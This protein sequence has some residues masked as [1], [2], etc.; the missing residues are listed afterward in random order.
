[1]DQIDRRPSEQHEIR[2]PRSDA[3]NGCLPS[4][5]DS[6]EAA[7]KLMLATLRFGLSIE[8]VAAAVQMSKGHFQRLFKRATGTTPHNWR[9]GQKVRVSQTDLLTGDFGLTEIAHRYGFADHA[10]YTR[11]FKQVVGTSPRAWREH[12]A[13]YDAAGSSTLTDG[14]E[15]G[16]SEASG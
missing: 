9:L 3:V 6:I 14:F 16:R 11:V 8:A 15:A 5:Q 2:R 7:K 12:A 13:L 1:M 10:H 4:E